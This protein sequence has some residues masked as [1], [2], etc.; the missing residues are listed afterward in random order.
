MPDLM[1]S[2]KRTASPEEV[3]AANEEL[4]KHLAK[5]H[6]ADENIRFEPVVFV[7][8]EGKGKGT[9]RKSDTGRIK[10]DEFRKK[11]INNF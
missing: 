7:R 6:H 2:Y 9:K 8:I 3:A 1:I 4:I 5:I 10:S 11:C